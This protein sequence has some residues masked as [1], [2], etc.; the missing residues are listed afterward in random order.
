MDRST[1]LVLRKVLKNWVSHSKPP[2]D[3]RA[4]L[5]WEAA[6]SSKK[7]S[8]GSPSF[9]QPTIGEHSA[10]TANGWSQT[11]FFSWVFE[12]TIQSGMSVRVC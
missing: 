6:Q 10:N 7:K 3:G 9:I 11:L 2:Q 12:H 4:R 1:D 8:I 5:L